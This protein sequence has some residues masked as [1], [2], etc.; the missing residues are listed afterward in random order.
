MPGR[1]TGATVDTSFWGKTKKVIT[2][3]KPEFLQTFEVRASNTRVGFDAVN[4]KFRTFVDYQKYPIEIAC[5][6]DISIKASSFPF[7]PFPLPNSIGNH[8]ANVLIKPELKNFSFSRPLVKK[9]PNLEHKSKVNFSTLPSDTSK[10]KKKD[11]VANKSEVL[12][13]RQI[14]AA[15]AASLKPTTSL[16]PVN[17]VATLSLILIPASIYYLQS[18]L[19]KE[20]RKEIWRSVQQFFDRFS[21]F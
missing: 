5:D 1:A 14:E 9:K 12:R 4:S 20:T 15:T 2:M 21:L 17:N 18:F 13:S 3:G 6:T 7:V 16:L 8:V 10:T 19:P 11:V